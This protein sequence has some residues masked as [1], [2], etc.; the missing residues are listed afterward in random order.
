MFVRRRGTV[1]AG[2]SQGWAQHVSSEA[3]GTFRVLHAVHSA[4]NPGDP[5]T[6]DLRSALSSPCSA[7]VSSGRRLPARSQ[8]V[9]HSVFLFSRCPSFFFQHDYLFQRAPSSHATGPSSTAPVLSFLLPGTCPAAFALGPACCS[10]SRRIRPPAEL[11]RGA[12]FQRNPFF[13]LSGFFTVQRPHRCIVAGNARAWV[14]SAA[15]RSTPRNISTL[16]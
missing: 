16:H 11:S 15:V 12:V 5:V 7:P 9:S 6:R 3:P 2:V 8:S 4:P 10:S 1:T 13:F 14:T